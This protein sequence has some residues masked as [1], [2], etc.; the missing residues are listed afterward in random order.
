MPQRA[1]VPRR[2]A[3]SVRPL[4]E[5]LQFGTDRE[6]VCSR[7]LHARLGLTS[8][9]ASFAHRYHAAAHLQC[10]M[11]AGHASVLWNLV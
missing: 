11:Q 5:V 8:E 10:S 6:W 7:N 9:V 1:R 4:Q 3:S 2:V